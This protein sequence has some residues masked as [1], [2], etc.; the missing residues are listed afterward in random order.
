MATETSTPGQKA[1]TD[2]KKDLGMK[3]GLREN[4]HI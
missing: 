2:F 3:Y 1:A 4:V